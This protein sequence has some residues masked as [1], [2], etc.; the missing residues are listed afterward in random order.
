[1]LKEII[2]IKN[3]R[4]MLDKTSDGYQKDIAYKIKENNKYKLVTHKEVRDKVKYLSAKLLDMGLQ[5]KKIAVMGDNSMNWEI[6][7]LATCY[8]GAIIVPIDKT[9]P[10]NEIERI[11]KI[12]DAVAVFSFAKR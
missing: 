10:L 5:N 12:S 2:D 9:L 11:I 7:Y 3:L 4:E 6:V 1:M 8:S